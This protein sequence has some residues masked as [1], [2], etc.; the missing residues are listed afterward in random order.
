MQKI[1]K[2]VLPYKIGD[3]TSMG[4]KVLNIE[5]EYKDKYYPESKYNMLMQKDKHAVIKK[6]QTM[7]SLVRE[8]KTFL[9]YF[10]ALAIIS[11]LKTMLGI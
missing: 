8:T 11:F 2:T 9:Y 4:W 5:Y 7:E 3:T 10:I 1:R 6:K